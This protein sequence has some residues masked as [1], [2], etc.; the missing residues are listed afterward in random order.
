MRRPIPFIVPALLF[1][2]LL[3][4]AAH[5]E[6]TALSQVRD[7][8]AEQ[9]QWLSGQPNAQGWNEYLL[10]AQLHAQLDR[11]PKADPAAVENILARY[12]APEPGV[13]LPQFVATRKALAAWLDELKQPAI[14]DLPSVARAAKDKFQPVTKADVL[15]EEVKTDAAVHRLDHYLAQ[16]GK[17]GADWRAHLNLNEL[18]AQLKK[19]LD[20][21]PEVLHKLSE[22]F[23]SGDSGLELRQFSDVGKS[24]RTYADLLAT[25]HNPDQKSQYDKQIDSLASQIETAAKQPADFDRQQLGETIDEL[26]ATHK[27]QALV[28]ALHRQFDQPNV[29]VNVSK[30]LVAGGIDDNLNEKTPINDVI[31]GTQINGVGDTTGHVSAE[32]IPNRD[33]AQIELVLRG[34][35]LSRTVGHNGPVTIFSHSTTSL[36]GRKELAFDQVAFSGEPA[37]ADCCTNSTIDC[38]DICGGFIIQH[39]ATRRVYASKST[40]EAISA[41]HAEARLEHRMDTRTGDLLDRV[42]SAFNEQFRYPLARRGA[43][44]QRIDFS[45]TRDWLSIVGL[46]A[47]S[48]E[49]GATSPP[50]EAAE[51]ADISIRLHDSLI[52]NLSAAMSAGKTTRS[53]AYRRSM[54]DLFGE[55]YDRE[56][57]ND[58]LACLAEAATPADHRDDSLLIPQKNFASLEKDRLNLD[59]TPADY[60]ALAKALADASLTAA[61]YQKF[62][63]GLA[64]DPPDYNA[65]VATLKNGLTVNYSATTFA[66]ENPVEAHFQDGQVRLVLRFKSTTQPK[67]DSDGNRIINPYPAEVFVTYKLSMAGGEVTATRVEGEYG[68]KAVP[69]PGGDANL[70]LRERTKRSTLLTKTLPR[71]FFGTKSEGGCPAGRRRNR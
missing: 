42:N 55:S 64:K 59:V 53:L 3:T 37:W 67:L 22:E 2:F 65:L 45:T 54:R 35:T 47:R 29:L 24:L 12:Q 23:F 71:R 4:T 49:T 48:N 28:T 9:S 21:D 10:T 20:A 36:M 52:D 32:L 44:P 18:Q 60:N 15:A 14:S 7:S 25:Y 26:A 27:N 31:L 41:D 57:F 51:N 13:R 58:F 6:T 50:P 43:F 17:N 46:E 33:R 70:S 30:Q 56:E 5:A 11:G 63:S 34:Q 61:Q 19:E 62:L 1:A 16:S 69:V 40:A 39:I 68:V 38:L 8:L 66:D